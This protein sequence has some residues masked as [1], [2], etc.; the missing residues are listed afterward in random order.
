MGKTRANKKN[1]QRCQKKKKKTLRKKIIKE[2]A[3][4]IWYTS[5]SRR[6]FN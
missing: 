6:F 5:I 2:S 1:T 4:F 3:L